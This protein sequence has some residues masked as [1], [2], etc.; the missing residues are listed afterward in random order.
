MK[1]RTRLN[2]VVAGLGVAFVAVL[3]SAWV[4][5]ARVSVSEEITAAHRVAAQLLGHIAATHSGD[6]PEGLRVF[7]EELGRI[8][9]QDVTLV[10]ASGEVLY[11]SPESTWKAGRDAPGWFA[12]LLTPEQPSRHFALAGGGALVLEADASRAVLDAWDGFVQLI[13]IAAVMLL[14]ANGAAFWLVGRALA[15]FPVIAG[16]LARIRAGELTFRLPPLRGAEAREMGTAFNAMAEAV[17]AK[18]AAERK[19]RDAEHRLAE[20]RELSRVIEQHIEEERRLIAHELHDEFSQSV[21]AIRSLALAIAAQDNVDHADGA[22]PRGETARLIADEAARLYDAM[23][24]LIPRLQPLTLDTLGLAE[25]IE[26]LVRDWQRRRPTVELNAHCRIDAELGHSVALAVYRVVQEGL[27]NAL[28]HAN[29]GRID[30]AVDADSARVVATVEDDGT[31]LPPDWRQPGR[32]GL[33]GLAERVE[34]L[35][36]ELEVAGRDAGGVA[37]RATIP[38]GAA[39]QGRAAEQRRAV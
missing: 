19:A 4:Q 14:I 21:T 36:G 13:A 39:E 26:N 2:F 35:G 32:F 29:A 37:L 10:D 31:G 25:T 18:V 27:I 23:H 20:K 17:E 1:L 16:G 22:D 12:N 6:A 38:L 11:R 24:G 30:I 5:N 9:A 28:R 3:L 7:L 8:R 15:P 33:R 34:G